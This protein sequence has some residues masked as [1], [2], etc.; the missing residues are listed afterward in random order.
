MPRVAYSEDWTPV[1]E[2]GGVT[3]GGS[4]TAR[5][6]VPFDPEEWKPIEEQPDTFIDAFGRSLPGVG[7]LFPPKGQGGGP[8]DLI[9]RGLGAAIDATPLVYGLGMSGQDAAN[10]VTSPAAGRLALEAG[11]GALATALVPEAAIP[12]AIARYGVPAARIL[13]AGLGSGAGSL[14]AEAVDP[15]ESPMRRAAVA[16]AFGAAGQGLGEAVGAGIGALQRRAATVVPNAADEAASFADNF[17]EGAAPEEAGKVVQQALEGDL[18]AFREL[19]RAK[20]D[21]LAA[22]GIGEVDLQ[23]A[24]ARANALVEREPLNMAAQGMSDDIAKVMARGQ[25]GKVPFGLA[26]HLRST[27]AKAR[28]GYV[29]AQGAFIPAADKG[30]AKMLTQSVDEQMELAA[31]AAGDDAVKLWRDFNEFWRTGKGEF[32][33]ALIQRITRAE[34]EQ[35]YKIVRTATPQALQRLRPHLDDESWRMIAGSAAQDLFGAATDATTGFVSGSKVMSQLARKEGPFGPARLRMLFGNAGAER[36][37]N[38]AKTL[39]STESLDSAFRLSFRHGSFQIGAATSSIGAG[40]GAAI[41]GVPGAATGAA[42]ALTPSA[43]AK[44]LTVPGVAPWLAVA[45]KAPPGSK[46]ASRAFAQL[47]AHAAEPDEE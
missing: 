34:P 26:Q 6:V 31:R 42:I 22:R 44:F 28:G 7:N 16:T 38:I 47:A 25:D 1:D 12:A 33:S 18:S 4:S 9:R 35:V 19:A 10:A 43:F 2:G 20:A 13:A 27:L 40:I 37:L 30:A 11:G 24:L 36:V 46:L 32:N 29:N 14:A 45:L 8:G 5:R 39:K 17:L 23:P 15:S 21:A 41:G 3:A